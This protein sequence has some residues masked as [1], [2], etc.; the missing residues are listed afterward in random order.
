MAGVDDL[1]IFASEQSKLLNGEIRAR[2]ARLGTLSGKVQEHVDRVKIMEEHLKNVAQEVGNTNFLM[3]A[4]RKEITTEA[5]LKAL[6]DREAGRYGQELKRMDTEAASLRDKLNNVQN[7]M[8]MANEAMDQFKLQM[9]WNQGEL[10]QWA[11]AARQKDEDN[12]ALERYRREDEARARELSLQIEKLSH[13]AVEKRAVLASMSAAAAAAQVELDR[14]AIAFK[15]LHKERQTLVR[16]WQDAVAAMRR[17][18]EEIGGVGK[19]FAGAQARRAAREEL[20]RQSAQRLK[21]QQEDNAEVTAQI[22]LLERQVARRKQDQADATARLAEFEDELDVVRSALSAGA[23][24]LARKR[25]EN[26]ALS[27]QLEARK[28]A[29]EGARRRY[30]AAKRKAEAEAGRTEGTDAAAKRA[31]D[32]LKDGQGE[33]RRVTRGLA[34]LKDTMFKESQKLYLRRQE[35]ADMITRVAGGRATLKNLGGKV[36]AL[37]AEQLRQQE[38]I[39]TAEFQIQQME[40]KVARG[41]GERS[42]EE[43]AGLQARIAELETVAAAERDAR[44]MLGS[45]VQLD[46]M[47]LEARR[48]RDALC[49]RADAVFALE[50]RRARLG[51]SVEERRAEVAAHRDVRRAAL[52]A[53]EEERHRVQLELGAR[54]AAVEKLRAKYETLTKAFAPPEGMEREGGGARGGRGPAAAAYYIIAAAQRREELQREGDELDQEIQKREREMRALENTLQHLNAR[55]VDFRMSFARADP[56]GGQA[57]LLRQLEQQGKLAQDALFRKKKE[58]QRLQTDLEEDA[59]RLETLGAQSERLRDQNAS[60]SGATAQVAA[61]LAA[62]DAAA[63][64][65]ADRLARLREAH[66]SAAAA[67]GGGGGGGGGGET[68]AE[69]SLRAEAL[70]DGAAGVLFTLG[71]LAREFPEMQDALFAE[72]QRRGLTLR[73]CTAC[74]IWR[75]GANAFVVLVLQVNVAFVRALRCAF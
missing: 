13:S 1:P 65:A 2:E 3:E 22:E 51:V 43:K 15:Q 52:R 58:V 17:R 42:D 34:T 71:Q 8:F 46:L 9:N 37:D 21:L 28:E 20:V 35:E 57:D 59:A 63:R 64:K 41:L 23:V 45:A 11:L 32:E 27:A 73:E 44:K 16:Q 67:A 56:D 24:A 36:H 26:G 54:R 39:Y 30:D 69:K 74:N 14:T 68:L 38:L 12:L 6:A 47:K 19:K 5:H 25:A 40:R 7:S 48:L 72:V 70:R 4:K 31:E 10:E 61:D 75:G 53:A 33:L 62:C 66:R 55:N 18:D 50:A 60:L 49:G 29:L